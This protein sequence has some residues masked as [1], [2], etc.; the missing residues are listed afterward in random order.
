MIATA[1]SALSGMAGEPLYAQG[2]D[3][4]A[5]PNPYKMQENWAQLPEGRKFGAAIKVQV[6]HSDGKSIWVFDRCGATEC[7]NSTL[8]PMEKFDSSGK[9]QKAIGAEMFAVPHGFYVDREG[10]VWGGDQIA[11]N[12]KGADLIKFAPD[13]KGV[14]D[15]GQAGNA[16]QRSRLFDYG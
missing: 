6:D 5:A 11:R 13:G 9:F 4:N 1:A 14:D 10:N 3:P 7:T 15:F 2:A 8:A 16:R 12:G